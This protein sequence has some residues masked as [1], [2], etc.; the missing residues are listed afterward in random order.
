MSARPTHPDIGIDLTYL[1]QRQVDAAV[2]AAK[3]YGLDHENR[4]FPYVR[5]WDEDCI[6]IDGDCTLARLRTLVRIMEAIQ[7]TAP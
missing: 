6:Q 7:P 3:T 2:L 5:V 4:D 1:P